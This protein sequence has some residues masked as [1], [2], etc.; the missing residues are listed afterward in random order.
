VS[1]VEANA[2]WLVAQLQRSDGQQLPDVIQVFRPQC[3]SLITSAAQQLGAVEPTDV[4]CLEA[5]V[6]ESDRNFT[7]AWTITL[8]FLITPA[9]DKP[10]HHCQRICGG[11]VAICRPERW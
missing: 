10:P 6:A 4:L 9:L 5:V 2:S 11:E 7:A 3:L 1:T 8:A